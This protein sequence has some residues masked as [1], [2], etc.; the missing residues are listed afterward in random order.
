MI[1]YVPKDTQVVFDEIPE[2]VTLAI[3]IS[4]CQNNCVGCHSSYLKNDIGE[5]LNRENIKK[6]ISEYPNISCVCFMGEGKDQEALIRAANIFQEED[7]NLQIALYSGRVEV[8]PQIYN[9]FDYVKVGPYI[10][11]KGPLTSRTT[12]Q[13]LYHVTHT[14]HLNEEGKMIKECNKTD[15]TE[16]FWK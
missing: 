10:E 12:N 8:E 6:L 3:N 7:Y 16:K 15:I 5:E 11:E 9:T 13:R 1:K 14:Y 2:E 4:N